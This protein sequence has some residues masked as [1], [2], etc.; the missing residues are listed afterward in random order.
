MWKKLTGLVVL[1]GG[2][3]LL[4]SAQTPAQKEKKVEKTDQEIAVERMQKLMSAYELAEEGRKKNAPEYLITAAGMMRRLSAIPALNAVPKS[5]IKP[6]VTGDNKAPV[7]DAKM[8]TLRE[9]S[10][11]LFKEAS[12]MGAGLNVNVD[13]L[14]KLAK[15]RET[16][17]K[18]E[19]AVVGGPK[20]VAKM[21]GPG[22]THTYDY[23]LLTGAY[24]QWFF[25]SS[26]PLHVSVVHKENSYIWLDTTTAF[27]SKVWHPNWHPN[28]KVKQAVIV[29][30]VKNNSKQ[31]AE[32]QMMIQ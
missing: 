8:P 32:Y 9:Q 19:R 28:P 18:E 2:S 6:E 27:A 21:I 1:A 16:V 22:Q 24:S 25:K 20:Q 13:K 12:D 17:D 31:K 7:T 11:E 23:T 14:I 3:I 4:L 15:E 26:I 30:R 10:D 5:D 29:I